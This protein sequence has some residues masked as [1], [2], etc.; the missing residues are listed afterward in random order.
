[1]DQFDDSVAAGVG[2]AS[3]DSL[4]Q[5]DYYIY[6]TGKDLTLEQGNDDIYGGAHFRIIDSVE[7][8][9]E[10]FLQLDNHEHHEYRR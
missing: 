3:F 1:M 4:T 7:K 2:A 6:A 8:T 9:Y 10:L 5:G